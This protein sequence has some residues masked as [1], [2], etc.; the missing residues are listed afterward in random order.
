LSKVLGY[1]K[2]LD[3]VDTRKLEPT[4]QTS[5]LI[6]VS[7]EDEI[8]SEDRLNEKEALSG[9]EKTKNSYFQVPGVFV[10]RGEE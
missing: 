10:E 3:E 6:N 9:T 7:R 4:S 1:I 8:K 2:E 5:G